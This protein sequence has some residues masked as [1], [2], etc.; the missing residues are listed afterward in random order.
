MWSN[1]CYNLLVPTAATQTWERWD[2]NWLIILNTRDT[3]PSYHELGQTLR[4]T[5]QYVDGSTLC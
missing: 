4:L 3:H 1:P 2:D 5:K